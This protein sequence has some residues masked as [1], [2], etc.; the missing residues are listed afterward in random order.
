[1]DRAAPI[2][3]ANFAFGAIVLAFIVYITVKGELGTYLQLFLYTPPAS[4]GAATS[5]ATAAAGS[6][7]GLPNIANGLFP[8]LFA[9]TPGAA[10][11][12]ITP[13]LQTVPGG[14]AH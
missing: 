3:T 12:V 13:G 11:T 14:A 6:N 5:P 10:T 4:A 7:F 9:P 8:G 1:M 2:G